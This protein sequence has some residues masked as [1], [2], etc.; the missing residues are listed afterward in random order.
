[1]SREPKKIVANAGRT[2]ETSID[3]LALVMRVKLA[4]R[5]DRGRHSDPSTQDFL[6]SATDGC[7]LG[8]KANI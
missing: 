8:S 1:M 2:T 3:L 6:L 4:R 5:G 7:E